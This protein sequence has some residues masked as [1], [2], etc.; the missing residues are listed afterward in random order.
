M[1]FFLRRLMLLLF[2]GLALVASAPG[3]S[4]AQSDEDGVEAAEE[5]TTT[6][7]PAAAAGQGASEFRPSTGETEKVSGYGLMVAAYL[8]MWG[9]LVGY[10]VLLFA[11]QRKIH[12][13]LDAL[14][15]RIDSIDEELGER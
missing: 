6:P 1:N 15:S 11:R 2:L 7:P 10:A 14:R 9:L 8:V 5:A 12:N 3:E 4:V 13:D